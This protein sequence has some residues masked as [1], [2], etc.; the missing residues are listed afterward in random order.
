MARRSAAKTRVAARAAPRSAPARAVF[1]GLQPLSQ[2]P[3]LALQAL[4]LAHRAP[5]LAHRALQ[6]RPPARPS[7]AGA[8]PSLACLS[9]ADCADTIACNGKERCQTGACVSG[10]PIAC[11][12]GL[13]CTEHGAAAAS[14]D[15][16]TPGR[17]L[18]FLGSDTGQFPF[19]LRATAVGRRQ[20]Q[21][22][23]LHQ[24]RR[25]RQR[26]INSSTSTAGRAT[27]GTSSS[28]T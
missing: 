16:A 21:R 6:R 8:P 27:A 28:T 9:D 10:A 11:A 26:P 2:A 3:H 4:R 1:Q 20:A 23:G 15:F 12:T 19:E 24:H 13:Q 7:D 22:V 5:H 25:R 17:W 18:T 14:C